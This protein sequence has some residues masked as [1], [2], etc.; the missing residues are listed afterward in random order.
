MYFP[1]VFLAYLEINAETGSFAMIHELMTFQN[2]C[3]VDLT[4]SHS[5]LYLHCCNFSWNFRILSSD[6]NLPSRQNVD[7]TRNCH[8][9]S[10]YYQYPSFHRC[11]SKSLNGQKRMRNDVEMKERIFPTPLAGK[12][13]PET[14]S[15]F[16]Y[17][18]LG[19]LMKP[20]FT[21]H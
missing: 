18:D 8:T 6:S 19:I 3:N 16:A 21:D 17:T 9:P 20:L 1:Y 5:F 10:D 12:Q 15:F 11:E 7:M 14:L 2:V 4:S 13:L